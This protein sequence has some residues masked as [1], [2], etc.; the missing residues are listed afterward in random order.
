LGQYQERHNQS[1]NQSTEVI[2]YL[3]FNNA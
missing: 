2:Y 1:I 3:L